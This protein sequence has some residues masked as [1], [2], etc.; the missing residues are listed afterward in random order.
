MRRRDALL[1]VRQWEA[2]EIAEQVRL[3]PRRGVN[4]K[5]RGKNLVPR[6]NSV[7]VNPL[8]L[9]IYLK[10]RFGPPNDLMMVTRTTGTDNIIQWGYSLCSSGHHFKIHGT[11][12]RVEFF[13]RL[14]E[15][16]WRKLV[17]TI[18]QD[19]VSYGTAMSEIRR[20]LTKWR[21]FINPFR[22][23]LNTVHSLGDSLQSMHLRE[24]EP[25][26]FI[27]TQAEADAYDTEMATWIIRTQTVAA[28]GT[29]T[30]MLAPVM[31]E[32]FVNFMLFVLGR[33]DVRRDE[34]LYE[35]LLRQPID[36]RVRSFHLY[37][38]GFV[39][40]VDCDAEPYKHFHSLMNKRNDLLH[41]NV[42]PQR[43]AFEEVYFDHWGAD[44]TIPLFRDDRSMIARLFANAL[45]FVEPDAAI[46]D[47]RITNEF[48]DHIMSHLSDDASARFVRLLGQDYLGWNPETGELSEQLFSDTIVGGILIADAK[49]SGQR[50]RNSA[51]PNTGPEADG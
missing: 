46:S 22:R 28:L 26:S 51:A 19:F 32:A 48:I 2:A 35:N 9:Y 1:N 7:P 12:N 25:R 14:T 47:I 44:Q 6:P 42:D 24:P 3:K 31:A 40:A 20:S 10:A 41:G 11:S 4:V 34:R 37:C 29:C 38:E 23:L 27:M 43:L 13:E 8:D 30:R 21:L 18:K 36:V 50:S 17:E 39:R 5:A 15:P 45:K 16:D 33:A 49:R